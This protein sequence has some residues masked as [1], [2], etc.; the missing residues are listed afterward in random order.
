M[1]SASTLALASVALLMLGALLAVICFLVRLSR[2]TK[3]GTARP[4]W[5]MPGG[6][7]L[8]RWRREWD[9]LVPFPPDPIAERWDEQE[10]LQVA[11]QQRK[12]STR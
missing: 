3:P 12:A 5:P 6:E 9:P 2:D 10:A 7:A 8:P 1:P 11:E 4:P